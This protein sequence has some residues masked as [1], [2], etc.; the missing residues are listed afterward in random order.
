MAKDIGAL[1]AVSHNLMH[2]NISITDGVYGI[3]SNTDVSGQIRK[4]IEEPHYETI[5]DEQLVLLV[6]S[7][8]NRLEKNFS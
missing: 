4:L 2:S 5:K 6:R 1:K 8:L 3:L 7:F